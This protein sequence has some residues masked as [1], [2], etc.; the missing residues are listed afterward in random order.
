[1][2]MLSTLLVRDERRAR[3]PR[4]SGPGYID[5]CVRAC[6]RRGARWV[7]AFL[8]CSQSS[9]ANLRSA[10]ISWN[11]HTVWRNG[12]VWC[13]ATSADALCAVA[14]SPQGARGRAQIPEA[15]DRRAALGACLRSHQV[16]TSLCSLR[17]TP[18]PGPYILPSPY[19]PVACHW[20]IPSDKARPAAAYACRDAA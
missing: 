5:A 4:A 10:A 17:G 8:G 6:T 13:A 18:L 1:M 3:A 20:I 14:G 12:R 16:H 9:P 2:S 11:A 15:D 19:A 7:H